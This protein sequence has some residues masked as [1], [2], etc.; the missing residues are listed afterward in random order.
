[1]N[2][3][4]EHKQAHRHREQTGDCWGEGQGADWEFEDGRCKLLHVGWIHD[5]VLPYS[6]GNCIQHPMIN[7]NGKE[8]ENEYIY[9]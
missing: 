7:R 2:L 5:K 6:M 9:V 3:S 1:M 4:T 8:Y